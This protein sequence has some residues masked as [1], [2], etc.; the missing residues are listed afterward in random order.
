MQTKTT[1]KRFKCNRESCSNIVVMK[2]YNC[3]SVTVTCNEIIQL[4][5]LN[6][7]SRRAFYVLYAYINFG[8]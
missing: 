6:F 3:N 2:V 7:L 8:R 1:K 5:D 4:M